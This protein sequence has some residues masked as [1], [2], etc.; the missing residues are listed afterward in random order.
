M[1]LL[2]TALLNLLLLL[3][4]ILVQC[5]WPA[6]CTC[7]P[8]VAQQGSLPGLQ[9]ANTNQGKGWQSGWIFQTAR[10]LL[11]NAIGAWLSRNA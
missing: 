4:H 3:I 2:H 5:S 1:K 6:G 9:E 8:V 7:C 11:C 10:R